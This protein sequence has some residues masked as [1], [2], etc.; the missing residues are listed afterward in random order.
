M[1]GDSLAGTRDLLL[2]GFAGALRRAELVGI[3]R[4]HITFVASGLR[5][6]IPRSKT[7]GEGEGGIGIPRGKRPDATKQDFYAYRSRN[8]R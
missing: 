2:M 8:A 4:E 7:D 3:D 6:L 1:C 5:L